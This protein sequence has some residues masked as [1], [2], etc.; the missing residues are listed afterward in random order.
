M[1][2][3]SQSP[4]RLASRSRARFGHLAKLLSHGNIGFLVAALD[5]AVILLSSV[6]AGIAYHYFALGSQADITALFGIGANASLLFVLITASRGYYRATALL[7]ATGQAKA[8]I[9][10]WVLVLLITTTLLFLMKVGSSYSRAST[11]GFGLL[12]LPLLLGVGVFC[13]AARRGTRSPRI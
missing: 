8:I 10:T 9:S 2:D 6:A 12:G 5:F 7:S 1:T 11:M 13:S 3:L 4:N